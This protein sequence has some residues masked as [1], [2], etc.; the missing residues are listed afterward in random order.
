MWLYKSCSHGEVFNLLFIRPKK[1]LLFLP[2][3]QKSIHLH[4]FT[5]R[6]KGISDTQGMRDITCPEHS[7]THWTPKCEYQPSP[8]GANYWSRHNNRALAY[9]KDL[10][11]PPPKVFINC[12]H[13]LLVDL[14]KDVLESAVISLQNCVLGAK[15]KQIKMMEIFQGTNR[16]PHQ[17]KISL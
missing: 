6:F 15:I 2:F 11:F 7:S 13:L 5:R 14:L 16:S 10:N 12:N 17:M 3:K 9:T 4:I 1:N 8:E